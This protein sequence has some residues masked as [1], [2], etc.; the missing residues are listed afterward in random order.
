MKTKKNLSTMKRNWLIYRLKGALSIFN[1]ELFKNVPPDKWYQ[2][3]VTKMEIDNLIN[4]IK[5]SK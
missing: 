1:D 3:D 4:I 5:E 2:I